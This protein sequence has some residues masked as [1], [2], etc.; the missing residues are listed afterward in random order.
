[1]ASASISASAAMRG[2]ADDVAVQLAKL[3][4]PPLLLLLVT[5][6]LRGA[7]PA[8]RL[9]VIALAGDDHA[10]Q[11]RRHL[12]ADGDMASAFV[13]EIEEL[14]DELAAALF[15][16]KLHRLEHRAVV[17]DE[18]IPARDLAPRRDDVIAAGAVLG[19]KVAETGQQLHGEGEGR[20]EFG[21]SKNEIRGALYRIYRIF[22]NRCSVTTLILLIL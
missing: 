14:A 2:F 18:P 3:P 13:G 12:R 20:G 7:E 15:L 9:F 10:G 8:E 21:K 22:L 19:I 11:G 17:L 5:E 4:Q 6:K 1:M 16:V